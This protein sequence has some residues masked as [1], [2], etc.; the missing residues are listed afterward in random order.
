MT[1][2]MRLVGVSSACHKK[3]NACADDEATG[4]IWWLHQYGYWIHSRAWLLSFHLPPANHHHHHHHHLSFTAF[5]VDAAVAA[6]TTTTTTAATTI[7]GVAKVNMSF[8]R[9]ALRLLSLMNLC[10]LQADFDLNQTNKPF[11]PPTITSVR[12]SNHRATP[13]SDHLKSQPRSKP[14]ISR[15]Q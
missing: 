1:L 6:T 12:A 4:D 7:T 8:T 15:R 5:G 11:V 13:A 10:D 3:T 9:D 2:W 14:N